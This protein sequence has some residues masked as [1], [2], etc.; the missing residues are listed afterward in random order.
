MTYNHSGRLW[1]I[2]AVVY[3]ALSFIFQSAPPSL[4]WFR[5]PTKVSFKPALEPGIDMVGGTS[6]TYDIKQPEGGYH[7]DGTLA[8]GVASALKR[9]IDPLGQRNLVWRPQGN[10]RLEIQLPRRLDSADATPIRTKY[11]E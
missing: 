4:F 1:L 6:L 3:V 7:G 8:E 9:R 10:S 11:L 5:D 2:V